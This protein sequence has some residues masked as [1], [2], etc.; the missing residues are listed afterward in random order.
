MRDKKVSKKM[1]NN[2]NDR[3]MF[4]GNWQC[5]ECGAEITELPFEPSGD[6]PIFCRECHRQKMNKRRDFSQRQMF[7]G[8]WQCAE[9]GAKITELPFEPKEGQTLLC[10]DCYRKQKDN[11]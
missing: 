1:D 5:S 7:Q 8:D 6:R 2:S 3:Q 11:Q 10:R 9:C 4:Q